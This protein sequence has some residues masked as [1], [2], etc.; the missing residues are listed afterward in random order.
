MSTH[1]I[2]NKELPSVLDHIHCTD[3]LLSVT[4]ISVCILFCRTLDINGMK[5]VNA[6]AAGLLLVVVG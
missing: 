3:H 4:H 2:H 1:N 5:N 6:T